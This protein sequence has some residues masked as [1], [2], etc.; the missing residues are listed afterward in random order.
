MQKLDSQLTEFTIQFLAKLP[1][2]VR[3]SELPLWFPRAMNGIALR[4]NEK[5]ELRSFMRGLIIDDG[6]QIRQG[7]PPEIVRELVKLDSWFELNGYY[8]DQG[9]GLS[10]LTLV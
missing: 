10:S 2:N 3:P 7:F 1:E 9:P 4:V 5:N 8:A 6:P